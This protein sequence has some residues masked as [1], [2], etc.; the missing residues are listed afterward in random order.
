[1]SEKAMQSAFTLD[2]RYVVLIS[3]PFENQMLEDDR[4]LILELKCKC[5]LALFYFFH[6]ARFVWI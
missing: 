6:E 1:M 4:L 5:I 2:R 3:N